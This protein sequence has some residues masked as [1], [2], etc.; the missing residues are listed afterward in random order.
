MKFYHKS[1][2][3]SINTDKPN[4]VLLPKGV[5]FWGGSLESFPPHALEGNFFLSLLKL[6]TLQG[7]ITKATIV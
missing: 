4:I 1:V 7:G 2:L 6:I 3:Y 5:L